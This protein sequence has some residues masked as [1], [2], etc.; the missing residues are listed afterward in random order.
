MLYLLY[1]QLCS[2]LNSVFPSAWK[3]SVIT[4]LLREEDYE[5][6]ND[7]HPVSLLRLKVCEAFALNQLTEYIFTGKKY[8]TVHHSGNKKLH[9]TETLNMTDKIL[10]VING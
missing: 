4:P 10:D 2:L 6:P 1:Y 3:E 7:N 9:S 5:T 8:L